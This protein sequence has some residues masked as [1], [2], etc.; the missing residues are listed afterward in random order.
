[1]AV[2]PSQKNVGM[3]L[4]MLTFVLS[5]TTES[6]FKNMDVKQFI[7][8]MISIRKPPKATDIANSYVLY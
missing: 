6:T 7:I 3:G 5:A 4:I 2:K 8:D 1:M